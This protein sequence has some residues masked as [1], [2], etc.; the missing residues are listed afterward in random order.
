VIIL[1]QKKKKNKIKRKTPKPRGYSMSGV[2]PTPLLW[3][4]LCLLCRA[5]DTQPF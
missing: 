3:L 4:G 5:A 1:E 2:Q